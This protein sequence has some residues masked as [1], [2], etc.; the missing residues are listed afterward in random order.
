MRI[1]KNKN[2]DMEDIFKKYSVKL[3]YIL[4]EYNKL[5]AKKELGLK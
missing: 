4:K 5:K 1:L 3:Y 2:K